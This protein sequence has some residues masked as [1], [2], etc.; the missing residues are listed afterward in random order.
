M[1]AQEFCRCIKKVRRTVKLRP[2]Q[3]KISKTK[4][5]EGAAIAICVKSVLQT[6]GKT[7]KRFRCK[8]GAKLQTQTM[9]RKQTGG[10]VLVGSLVRTPPPVPAAPVMNVSKTKMNSNPGF[11]N[12]IASMF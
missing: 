12:Q 7:L 9:K 4:Q 3:P 10:A 11:L 6:R 5:K 1:L 2:G 8:K